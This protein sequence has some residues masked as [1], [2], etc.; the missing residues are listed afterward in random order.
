MPIAHRFS[1]SLLTCKTE[2]RAAPTPS[3]GSGKGNMGVPGQ[4]SETKS[5]M[6]TMIP[7]GGYAEE[8]MIPAGGVQEYPSEGDSCSDESGSAQSE[9]DSGT[10]AKKPRVRKW[11]TKLS[12]GFAGK[13]SKGRSPSFPPRSQPTLGSKVTRKTKSGTSQ[14]KKRRPSN[15]PSKVLLVDRIEPD[16]AAIYLRRAFLPFGRCDIEMGWVRKSSAL[17]KSARVAYRDCEDARKAVE[18]YKQWQ[19]ELGWRVRWALDVSATFIKKKASESG[20]KPVALQPPPGDDG[21]ARG[22]LPKQPATAL[23]PTASTTRNEAPPPT[24]ADSNPFLWDT[25][26][27]P[28]T[29]NVTHSNVSP[30]SLLFDPISAPHVMR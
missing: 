1:K 14:E 23:R 9:G 18:F 3:L 20:S 10:E 22:Q 24:D 29:T 17:Q 30:E 19:S 4:S 13:S 11:W 28:V 25:N 7:A 26:L 27:P 15:V 12:G 8:P 5:S 2:N 21:R 16:V 6:Y